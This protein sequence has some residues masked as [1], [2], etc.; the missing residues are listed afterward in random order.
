M[1][2]IYTYGKNEMKE[3]KGVYGHKESIDG[4]QRETPYK[5]VTMEQY[6][7]GAGS[8]FQALGSSASMSTALE[9]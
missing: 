6:L 8:C 2:Q 9:E 1:K 4:R 3:K 5:P 7:T